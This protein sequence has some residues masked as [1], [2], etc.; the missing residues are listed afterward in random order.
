MYKYLFTILFL[1]ISLNMKKETCYN[2]C[3]SI[4]PGGVSGFWYSISQLRKYPNKNYYCASSGCLALIST[5]LNPHYPY[6]FAKLSRDKYKMFSQIKN[7]FIHLIVNNLET[8]PNVTIVT[9]SKYGTCIERQPRDFKELKTLL[10]KTTDV[11]FLVKYTHR[12]IDGGLCYYYMNKCKIK[13]NLPLTFRFLYNLFNYDLK[14]SEISY[15]Y[16]YEN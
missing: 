9:M 7:N 13:I 1:I 5:K 15:F 3:V 12:E 6:N 8:L 11:P 2:N 16:N 14:D 4:P 10:I